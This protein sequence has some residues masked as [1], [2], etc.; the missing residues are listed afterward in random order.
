MSTSPEIRIRELL[1]VLLEHEHL[2]PRKHAAEQVAD[3]KP[4]VDAYVSHE[5]LREGGLESVPYRYGERYG[6]QY[7]KHH[8]DE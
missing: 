1:Y 6:T 5:P 3:R 8:S 2:Y 4:Q 7:R